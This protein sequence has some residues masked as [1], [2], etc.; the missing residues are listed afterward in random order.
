M[1]QNKYTKH[2][3]SNHPLLLTILK[4]NYITTL[5]SK[6]YTNIRK[7]YTEDSP[8]IMKDLVTNNHF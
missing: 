5:T 2:Q 1:N 6:K 8:K 7:N 3:K 4:M